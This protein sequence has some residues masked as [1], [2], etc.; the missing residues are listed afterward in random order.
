M[1]P[2]HDD[3]RYDDLVHQL[4]DVKTYVRSLESQ[5]A[6]LKQENAALKQENAKIKEEKVTKEQQ[7]KNFVKRMAD[8]HRKDIALLEA[9]ADK[10]RKDIALLEA[11]ATSRA[12]SHTTDSSSTNQY[13]IGGALRFV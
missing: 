9:Q 3:D 12:N 1:K 10:H 8:K 4:K 13:I 6:A 11:Q 7:F 5:N 2:L